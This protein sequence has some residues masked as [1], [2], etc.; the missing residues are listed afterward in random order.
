MFDFIFRS[1]FIIRLSSADLSIVLLL[2]GIVTN[3][4][5]VVLTDSYLVVIS[6]FELFKSPDKFRFVWL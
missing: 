1:F 4:I 3:F 6:M 2:S 5:V